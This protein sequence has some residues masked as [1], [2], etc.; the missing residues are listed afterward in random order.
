MRDM[1]AAKRTKVSSSSASE[2]SLDSS[3]LSMPRASRSSVLRSLVAFAFSLRTL[4]FSSLSRSSSLSTS[5]SS[6]SSMIGSTSQPSCASSRSRAPMC[7]SYVLRPSR[8]SSS[9]SIWPQKAAPGT[10][11]TSY[12]REQTK[13]GIGYCCAAVMRGSDGSGREEGEK[14]CACEAIVETGMASLCSGVRNDAAAERYV[15]DERDGEPM[16]E[17]RERDFEGE[18]EGEEEKGFDAT[19]CRSRRDSCRWVESDVK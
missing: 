7:S 17:E 4:R 3:S 11:L 12:T 16:A 15:D 8:R 19:F 6:S 18:E 14:T 1:R 2:S 9:H 10:G 13:V 5:L